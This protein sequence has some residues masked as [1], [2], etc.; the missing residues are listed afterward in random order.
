MAQAVTGPIVAKVPRT[1]IKAVR[2]GIGDEAE[3]AF[4][5]AFSLAFNLCNP[6]S[7]ACSNVDCRAIVT[8]FDGSSINSDASALP[9]GQ[10]DRLLIV[11]GVAVVSSDYHSNCRGEQLVSVGGIPVARSGSCGMWQ[12]PHRTR[13]RVAFD[14]AEAAIGEPGAGIELHRW[15]N[16]CREEF[17]DAVALRQPLPL[18]WHR[19]P[20]SCPGA[21]ARG[22]RSAPHEAPVTAC[23]MR[24][25]REVGRLKHAF[26]MSYRAISE[27]TGI[28][29]A[30]AEYVNIAAVIGVTWPVP[31]RWGT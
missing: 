17:A 9:H 19:L 25:V 15:G 11:V 30:A 27:A 28:G 22:W 1:A 3:R 4:I 20:S 5:T 31:G 8:G 12:V 13:A 21:T 29:K 23:S 6:A 26:G 14:V 24:K 18:T 10:S 16:D 2:A 7:L